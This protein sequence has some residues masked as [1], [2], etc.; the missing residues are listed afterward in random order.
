[1]LSIDEYL[2]LEEGSSIKHEYV[3]GALYALAGSTL[4]HNRISLRIA[5]VLMD[6]ADGTPCQ[7]YMSDVKCQVGNVFYYPDVMVACGEPETGNLTYRSDPCLLVEVTSPS[8]ASIDRREKLLIYRQIPTVRAY[9]IVDQDTRR[10]ERHYRDADGVWQRAD[11]L[12]D[13]VFRVPCPEVELTLDDI[14]RD[15]S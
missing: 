9:L 3:E 12:N 11:H 15:I 2:E 8:T 13:G 4:R 1:M 7:V 6:A 10:V 5:S 14:Y